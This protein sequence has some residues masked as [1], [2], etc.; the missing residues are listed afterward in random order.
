MRYLKNEIL[1]PFYRVN[2]TV[3]DLRSNWP[4]PFMKSSVNNCFNP[5]I[6]GDTFL[7]LIYY[8][9][10]KCAYWFEYLKI[11]VV[12]KKFKYIYKDKGAYFLMVFVNNTYS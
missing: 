6:L 7:N 11:F 10:E 1:I 5:N 12:I 9:K 8:F 3:L 2:V 4:T